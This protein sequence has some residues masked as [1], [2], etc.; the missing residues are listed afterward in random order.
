MI[1]KQRRFWQRV[2]GKGGAEQYF[3]SRVLPEAPD[4]RAPGPSRL[5]LGVYSSTA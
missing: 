4:K 1:K 5:R 2:I 3:D